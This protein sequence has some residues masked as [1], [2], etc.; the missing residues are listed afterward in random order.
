MVGLGAGA[1]GADVTS[2]AW[3][4]GML[5]CLAHAPAPASNMAPTHGS[6]KALRHE[7]R[8]IWVEHKQRP[9]QWSDA[10]CAMLA[11]RSGVNGSL[12]RRTHNRIV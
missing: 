10:D 5:S 3:G 8:F 12:L 2:G 4:Y 7:G 6:P 11:W 9:Y 1:I